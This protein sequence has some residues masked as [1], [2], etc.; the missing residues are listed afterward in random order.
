MDKDILNKKL[1][2]IQDKLE[3]NRRH[4]LEYRDVK[5][6]VFEMAKQIDE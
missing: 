5:V 6:N 2:N 1:H 3:Y 4:L